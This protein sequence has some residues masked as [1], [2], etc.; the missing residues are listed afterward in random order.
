LKVIFVQHTII[1]SISNYG[2][3]EMLKRMFPLSW[4]HCVL[5]DLKIGLVWSLVCDS[6]QR[7]NQ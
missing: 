3:K 7:L 2:I 6:I 4:G 1:Y 5:F